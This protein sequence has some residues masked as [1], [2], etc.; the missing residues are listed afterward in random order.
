M[1]LK[2]HASL[3]I[4]HTDVVSLAAN[5]IYRNRWS[6]AVRMFDHC[7][8]TDVFGFIVVRI[9]KYHLRLLREDAC[10][11]VT[12]ICHISVSPQ[13]VMTDCVLPRPVE[14]LATSEE[15]FEE[16]ATTTAYCGGIKL[17]VTTTIQ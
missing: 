12:G 15:R 13:S 2:E 10:D 5:A 4:L 9:A 11:T 3:P 14:A 16:Q 8:I 6:R 1:P 17:S 7:T